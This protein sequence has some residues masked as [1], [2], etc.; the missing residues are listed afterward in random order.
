MRC[1]AAP[2]A[3]RAPVRH[4][5]RWPAGAAVLTGTCPGCP[6]AADV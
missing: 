4:R 5:V 6:R 3:R 1:A 2:P